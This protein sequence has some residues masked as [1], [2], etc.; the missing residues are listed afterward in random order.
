MG[1]ILQTIVISVETFGWDDETNKRV[2]YEAF[3][4]V[5]GLPRPQTMGQ[6]KD[7]RAMPQEAITTGSKVTLRTTKRVFMDDPA[8]DT[9][10]WMGMKKKFVKRG[11]LDTQG[12]DHALEMFLMDVK[13]LANPR[14]VKYKCWEIIPLQLVVAMD[15]NSY[16]WMWKQ[17]YTIKDTMYIAVNAKVD[18]DNPHSAPLWNPEEEGFIA[19][20]IRLKKGASQPELS[21]EEYISNPFEDLPAIDVT[22]IAAR[23]QAERGDDEE[24]PLPLRKGRFGK[25]GRGR[26]GRSASEDNNS[27]SVWID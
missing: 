3:Y 27:N 17:R 10:F 22:E 11:R 6:V 25:R 19:E 18:K 7:R 13:Q 8:N 15:G 9:D 21:V 16:A 24:E 2:V 12:R 23:E 26:K 14:K 5:K 20:P 1:K 4:R